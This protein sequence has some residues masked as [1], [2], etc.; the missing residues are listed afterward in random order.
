MS[1]TTDGGRTW[2]RIPAP[3][4]HLDGIHF[5]T[6]KEG[7]AWGSDLYMTTDSGDTWRNISPGEHLWAV[8]AK[9]GVAWLLVGECLRQDACNLELRV[10]LDY[11]KTWFDSLSLHSSATPDLRGGVMWLIEHVCVPQQ[12]QSCASNMHI[13][14]NKGRSWEDAR[15][16][17]TIQ[18]SDFRL[19]RVNENEAWILSWRAVL[20][21]TADHAAQYEHF[22]ISTRDGGQTWQTRTFPCGDQMM[23]QLA[24]LPGG[25]VWLVCT[26]QYDQGWQYKEIYVS[27][28]RGAHWDQRAT[29]SLSKS[30]P[31]TLVPRY[32]VAEF[33]ALSSK[34]AWL[35]YSQYASTF[36]FDGGKTWVGVGVGD[37]GGG[38][39]GPVVFVDSKRGWF[40]NR[41]VVY[42]TEDAGHSWTPSL[43]N[44]NP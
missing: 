39:M 2:Q 14:R 16:Q 8:D 17:P 10:S 29:S 42:Y 37:G 22:L 15:I 26:G 30:S 20:S 5:F 1:K 18:G 38:G 12:S 28:D 7:L 6:A 31:G 40:G 43:L 44:T 32:A 24:G 25:Y 35:I 11:G 36:T 41:S 33:G 4:D 13:S 23:G 3:A 27:S 19:I 34:E 21:R 9:D